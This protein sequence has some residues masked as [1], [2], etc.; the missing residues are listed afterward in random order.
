MYISNC[1]KALPSL[2]KKI[3]PATAKKVITGGLAEI[4]QTV[5]RE[6]SNIQSAIGRAQLKLSRASLSKTIPNSSTTSEIPEFIYH[7][8]SGSNY[9][10][11]R[12][13]NAIKT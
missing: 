10:K 9:K 1:T 3:N 12:D 6:G 5:T 8:T 2:L 11:M 13:Y 7:F 4:G